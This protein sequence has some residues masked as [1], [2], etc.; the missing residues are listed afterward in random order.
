M[1]NKTLRITE[2]KKLLYDDSFFSYLA[3][4]LGIYDVVYQSYSYWKI[5]RTLI[6]FF[7]FPFIIRS[8]II[9][10]KLIFLL[11]KLIIEFSNGYQQRFFD[12]IQN[13][14]ENEITSTLTT[15][16]KDSN[17]KISLKHKI[18]QYIFN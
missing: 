3:Y 11:F 18:L 2:L 16:L 1:S 13:L 8:I 10:I 12:V 4:S 15:P 9:I 7:N 6:F 17:K 5:F 14:E